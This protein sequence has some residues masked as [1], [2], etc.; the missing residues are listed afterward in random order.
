M[1]VCVRLCEGLCA[2]EIFNKRSLAVVLQLNISCP[3][4]GMQK[5]FNIDDDKKL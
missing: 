2:V 1:K 3:E 5:S 4:L